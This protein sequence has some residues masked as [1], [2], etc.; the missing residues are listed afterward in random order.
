MNQPYILYDSLIFDL[1]K[2]GGISRYFCEIISRLNVKYDISLYYTENYYLAQ[3]KICKH[4]LH[5]PGFLFKHFRYKFYRKNQKLTKKLLLSSSPYLFHPTYYDLTF[6]K[7]IGDNPFVITV[8]D[9]TYERLPEYFSGAEGTI[10][11][12]KEIIT[13]ANRI[14]AISENTKKDIVEIL[15]IAPTKIDVIHHGTSIQ[16]PLGR[17]KLLLPN[18]YLLFVGDRT[19]YKNFQRLLEAF[20]N[21][22]K[23][24][25]DLYLICTGKP[26]SPEELQQIHKLHVENQ[27]LQFSVNDEDLSELY[28]RALLFVYPSL[29][30]GFGIPILEAYAC[31]CPVALSNTSCFPEIAGNAGAYFDP[32]SVEAITDTITAVINNKEERSRLI[33]AGKERLKLYSW[34]EAAQKTEMV[35]QKVLNDFLK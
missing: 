33:I 29:Y 1:Q 12:K 24:I 32:Y 16:P 14:I 13:K 34:E 9:M 5:I 11:L 28:S 18:K 27:T 10:Q 2:F 23:N 30:E 21:I 19:S 6:L 7:Y 26:F 15:N 4:H 22:Y 25:K 35:Y 31:N 3:S 17:Q 8:H 20:A